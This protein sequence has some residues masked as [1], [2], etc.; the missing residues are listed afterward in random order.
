MELIS[1]IDELNDEYKKII[2]EFNINGNMENANHEVICKSQDHI[3]KYIWDVYNE[4][5]SSLKKDFALVNFSKLAV[6]D[7]INKSLPV[8][9]FANT[10]FDEIQVAIAFLPNSV[11]E[12][13]KEYLLFFIEEI[14]EKIKLSVV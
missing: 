12:I 13:S 3:L 2:E 9:D 6:E 1:H 11:F 4:N 5:I 14:R 7:F 8:Q 10:Y